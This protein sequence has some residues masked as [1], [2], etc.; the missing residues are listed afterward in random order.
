MILTDDELRT[1]TGKKFRTSQAQV[2][3]FMGIDYKMRPDGSLV[4]LRS[5]LETPFA[6]KRKTAVEPNWDAINA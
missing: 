5:Q 4:V 3:R 1:L 2:L 6:V